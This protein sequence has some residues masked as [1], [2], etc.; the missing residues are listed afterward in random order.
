ML[1]ISVSTYAQGYVTIGTQGTQSGNTTSSPVNGYYESRHIQI[2]YTAAE[3]AVA[4]GVTGNISKL[5]WDVSAVYAGGALPGY[6]V[7]MAHITT[8]DIPTTTFITS[9]F[10]TVKTAFGYTPALGFN[11][12]TFDTPFNWNGTDNIV[13][14]ICFNGAPYLSPYGQCWNYTGVNNNYRSQQ[15]D[16]SDLCGSATANQTYSAKPRVRFLMQMASCFSP[17][18]VTAAATATTTGAVNWTASSSVPANGYQYYYSSTNTAPTASST[19][20]GSVGAGVTTAPLSGLTSNTTYYVWVRSVCSASENSSWSASTTFTTPCDPT[21]VPYY[22]DFNAVTTPAL[23]E[24]TVVQNAG[25]GNLW[26]TSNPNGSGFTTNALRYSWNGTNAANAW[27]FLRGIT[28]TAGTSYRV[29]YK[30]G[31]NSTFYTEKVKVMYGTANVASSMTLPLADHNAVTGGVPTT[32]FVDFIPATTGVYYIGFN[33]YSI[34]NQ[35]QLY[36]DDISVTVTP[37]CE[38]PTAVSGLVVSTTSGTVSWTASTSVPAEGYEYYYATTNTPPTAATAASGTVAA[39]VTTAAITGLTANTT[40]YVWVRSVCTATDKSTWEGIA[41]FFTGYC[42][43]APVSQDN[44]GITNFTMGTIN[45]TTQSETGYYGDYSAQSSS[46]S[47]GSTVNF[48][49]TYATGFTYGTKIWVDWNNDLDFNDEGEQVYYGLSTDANPTTL[50]GSFVV[51]VT[52]AL[53]NHRLRIGGT[54]NDLGGTPCYTGSWGSY[55]DYTINVFMPPAPVVTAFTPAS[56]CAATGEITITGTD[57]LNATLSIGGTAV[58]PL[59]SNSNTQIVATVPAG[60]TGTVSITTVAGTFTTAT[61]FTVTTPAAFTLSAEDA[62]I[63]NGAATTAIT[64][65]EGASSFDTYVWEP[66]TGVSGSAEAGWTFN[67]TTT[68]EYVLT[69]SQSAGPC[70]VN[71]MVNVTVN[72]LPNPVMVT[73]ATA[74]AC[75]NQPVM[76][77]ATGGESFI[78]ST[79]CSPT[80]GNVGASGDY[81]NNFSFANI[82]NNNSGDAVSDYTFYSALTANVT[83]GTAYD[84][85]LQSGN[86]TWLQYFRVW[87]DYDHSGTFEDSESVFNSTTGVNSSTTVTG[88]ITIP[89]TA[90]NGVTRM[91]VLCSYNTQSNATQDCAWTGFGEYEDYNVNI[92]GATNPVDYVWAPVTGLFTD[93]AATVPYVAG[94]ATQVVYALPSAT[95]TYTATASTDLGCSISGSSVL[96]LYNTEAPTAV[97]PQNFVGITYVSE[98]EATGTAIQWYTA[99]TGGTALAATTEVTSGT[100]YATQTLNGCES[101]VRTPV[102]ISVILPEMDW[103]NLQWPA[104]LSIV[105][106]STGDVYAQGYEPG[107]TP[108]AG[109]GIG[110]QAWIGVSTSNTNPNTWTTW[111]PMTFNTQVGN[112]DEF[113]AAI[114]AGLAPGTYYYASRFMLPEGPY[115]YGGYSATGGSFWDGT[116]AVSGVLTVTCGTPAPVG[117]AIQEI[118]TEGTVADLIAEGASVQWYAAA[119]GGTALSAGTALVDGAT[120]YATQTLNGCESPERFAV[121]V[122]IIEYT[123]DFVNLQWPAEVTVVEGSDATI[124]AQV[125]EPNVTPGAGPGIGVTVLIGISTENTDPSTWT[126]WIPMTFNTQVGNNDEFMAAVGA[127]LA[128]GTYYY[129]V[130][131]QLNDGAYVYGGY[132][133]AGGGTWDGDVNVSGVITVVCYT[134]APFSFSG[135]QIVCAGGT[136]ADLSAEGSEIQW[137]AAATGGVALTGDAAIVEGTVYY[138]SQTVNGCE[139]FGRVAVTAYINVVDAPEAENQEVSYTATT[140]ATIDD[141]VIESYGATITWYASEADALAGTNAIAPGTEIESGTYYAVA[142]LGGCTSAPV[143]VTVET[144]LGAGGFDMAAFSYWPNPV[145]NVLNVSYT[146]EITSVIVYNLIG[147]QVIALAPNAT[148]VKIDMAA[149]A[150]G[151]YTIK[152]FAGNSAE[153]IRVVKKQ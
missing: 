44:S 12:I 58:T 18:G 146:Q 23:P 37:T 20:S 148:E 26:Y 15:A 10:T 46:H 81:L 73:P 141:I 149:L 75:P 131:G 84:I 43:P 99:A 66:S 121:T 108:G 76:L 30:Y 34:A 153:T 122:S 5:A 69:A 59:T 140:A 80:V 143:A 2:V 4:G 29:S 62:T 101:V 68:T 64:V 150:E 1:C 53:G 96:T 109:P 98:L 111:I 119:T 100:Y 120:Y 51:P 87:I 79:Y 113:V 103:V 11:D 61:S 152:V 16:G 71:A 24:C 136:I 32:T 123:L 27:F 151:T 134:A 125:Y 130:A 49:V 107:I 118:V 54:D 114:G 128:P 63:C 14:D 22:Q 9:G 127:N 142:V 116:A 85:S 104:E 115:K 77:T 90:T 21:V 110:V 139:S 82:T 97:S 92:T 147:Q 28:L 129:A 7:K 52:A 60:V 40:Y 91:R 50:S 132:S 138:A 105:Q 31:N 93:A 86:P 83:G 94:T 126:E 47:L 78:P 145:S 38:A 57:L 95:A 8:P 13:I 45:N 33:A 67:P 133:A 72:P 17:T 3:M 70:V 48:S 56:Y 112:N 41:S 135:Q 39:G 89:A 88:S 106:G 35:D 74:S 25:T 144:V 42:T 137:Y 65:T 6:T 36:L 117:V 124:Y 102:V 19:P 55:E